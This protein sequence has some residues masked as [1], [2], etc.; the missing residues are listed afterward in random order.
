MSAITVRDLEIEVQATGKPIVRGVSLDLEPGKVLGVVGESGSGKS[1]LALALLGFARRGAR[2]TGGSIAVGGHDILSLTD[3]QLRDV[4]GKIVSYV[5]QDPATALN[6]ALS[7]LTQLSE[8][9]ADR[10]DRVE[11]IRGILGEVG[12]PSDDTFLHRSAG[13]LSGGQQQRVAIAMAVAPEPRLLVLDEP[14]TGLD[15]STQLKVLELVSRLTAAHAMAAIYI[16]H[17]LAVVGQVSDHVAVLYDGEVVETGTTEEVLTRGSHEY[18]RALVNAVPS[19]RDRPQR[20]AHDDAEATPV[21]QIQGLSAGYGGAPVLEDVSLSIDRGQCLAIVGESGSGKTTMSRCVIGL[22]APSGGVISLDGEPLATTAAR[23]T[24]LARQRMQYVFQNPYASLQPRQTIG[25]S[26]GLPLL[27]FKQETKA[28]VRGRIEE[29]L[30]R[31]RLP[32]SM[33]DRFPAELSGGQRQRV[34][35]ARA[36]AAKPALLV[37]D[38]ITSALDVSVQ[39]SILELLAGLQAEGQSMLFITH[40]LAVVA[41]IADQVAVLRKGRIVEAGPTGAVLDDPKDDYTKALLADTLDI[42]DYRTEGLVR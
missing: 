17:D 33:A 9:I 2:I 29:A 23:R 31:V 28:T 41:N 35:I 6:P 32:K 1:T 21:L 38:E 34:A 30:E 5:P 26:I 27:F 18:T 39:A 40:N 37:C 10:P 13:E 7:I 24:N 11:H 25:E 8:R 16:S 20:P 36:L 15:V 19:V 22:H 4:R 42:A 12:L 14:T 3:A